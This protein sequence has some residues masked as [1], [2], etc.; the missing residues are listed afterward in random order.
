MEDSLN[1]AIIGPM[2]VG[3]TTTAELL[4]SYRNYKRLSF[5][6]AVK[7]DVVELLN[8]AIETKGSVLGQTLPTISRGTIEK[9]KNEVFR[10][11]L[12]WYGTDFWRK[13]MGV[14]DFWLRRL[15]EKMQQ[16]PDAQFVIDDCRFP[17]EA[18][19]LRERG[20]IIVKIERTFTSNITELKKHASETEINNITPDVI[21]PLD[22]RSN[23]EILVGFDTINSLTR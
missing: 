20:F 5:A 11:F 2:G 7:D 3:K 10:P 19:F 21:F 22:N 8:H 16:N 15:D 12:Q 23:Q 17:N 13:Y 1:I 18:V 6:D 14:E 9:Y 4:V